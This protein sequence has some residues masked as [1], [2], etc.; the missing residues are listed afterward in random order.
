MK[1][2][3][4]FLLTL[5]CC[6]D[7]AATPGI[8]YHIGDGRTGIGKAVELLEDKGA[9]MSVR[10]IMQDSAFR[11]STQDVLNLGVSA[12]SFWIRFKVA[13]ESAGRLALE[14]SQPSIDFAALYTVSGDS[15]LAVIEEGEHLPF[16]ARQYKHQNYIF[17]L[18]IPPGEERE[19]L[20]KVRSLEQISLPLYIGNMQDIYESLLHTD[21]I[22]GVFFGIILVMFLYNLFLYFTVRDS[23]Y[24]YYVSY[25]LL[26]ALSQ[27]AL[28]GY[29]FRY[30]W[31]DS[32]W[33][34]QHSNFLFPS[35]ASIAAM[36]FAK[37][38]L[39]LRRYAPRL[40]TILKVLIGIFI[41]SIALVFF[42]QYRLSF[43]I[44]QN[45]TLL[46]SLFVIYIAVV[47]LRKGYKPAKYFLLAW[48]ALLVGAAILVLRDYGIFPSNSFTGNT[49]VFGSAIEVVLLSFALADKINTL[50]REKE[51]SQMQTLAAYAEN[52]RIIKEQNLVL[53][54]KVNERTQE[55]QVSNEEL[56]HTLSELKDAQTQL[57][58]SEKMASL[59]QLTAG[60]AHEINNPI[61]FVTSNV[62]PL[63][64]DIRLLEEAFTKIEALALS[65][66]PMEEKQKQVGEIKEE[67]EYD[68][69]KTEIEFLLKGIS[70]G[71]N[72]TAEIV[73]G[74]R[75]FSR[76]DEDDLKQ[77][78][79]HE[80][81]DSTLII[82]NTLLNNHI[83]VH[84]SYGDL[85]KV[86]CYPGKLNQVFL[87][88][89]T[90]GIHAIESRWKGESGG[91]LTIATSCEG[92]DVVIRL[93]DNGCGMAQ[94]TASHIF[95]PFFTT[96]GVGE[97]TGLGLS[98]VYNIIKK[99]NGNISVESIPGEGTSFIIRIPVKQQTV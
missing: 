24:L 44:M 86:E 13:N 56:N 10:E 27:A 53:E 65:E 97:G 32:T 68:Y 39:H 8:I 48:S 63:E 3:C 77:V 69:L 80:G 20:L 82:I 90:N 7:A 99:H 9:S 46:G 42:G 76:V 95:E 17:D 88:I 49:L 28:N 78:N 59:G 4:Y 55:L 37:V 61:N 34:A 92:E 40:D 35:L 29:S 60:I 94:E 19:F 26:L 58:E 12:S 72:R 22:F 93:G 36:W 18:K 41:L 83:S 79:I 75:I 14:L 43:M 64:R 91:A 45:N 84:C 15:V 62:T 51:E 89:L 25:I 98:I 71:S 5:F 54:T 50:R 31:P 38:F 96:K 47:I 33:M 23:S 73:K 85:P 21:I 30:L 66:L 1:L 70:E 6:S 67:I 57:V 52:E 87:N 16:S 11:P 81:I 2:I 74:L